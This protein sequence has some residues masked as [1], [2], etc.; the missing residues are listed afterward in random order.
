MRQ[1]I[2]FAALAASLLCP[3]QAQQVAKEDAIDAVKGHCE[4]DIGGTDMTDFCGDHLIRMRLHTKDRL[5]VMVAVRPQ[6]AAIFSGGYVVRTSKDKTIMEVDTLAYGGDAAPFESARGK[7]VFDGDPFG[8]D[9]VTICEAV[10]VK[11]LSIRLLFRA[12]EVTE[13]TPLS[14]PNY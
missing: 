13:I 11:L 8:A 5:S 7:C 3:V 4:L 14:E 2:V 12:N 10:S 6:R 1:C 9:H